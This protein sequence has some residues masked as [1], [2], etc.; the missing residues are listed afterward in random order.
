MDELGW[1]G[2]DVECMPPGLYPYE[3]IECYM[4]GVR[5]YLKFLKRGYSRVTQ[6]TA[7]DLRNG[8]ITKAEADRLIREFEGKKPPSLQIFLDFLDITENEFNEIVKKLIVPPFNPDF[9]CIPIA[10]KTAD[11]DMWY[12]ENNSK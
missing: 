9:A 6:M 5:D 1:K 10:A 8:R 3:K 4:Q 12:R 11:F 7:L 2:D